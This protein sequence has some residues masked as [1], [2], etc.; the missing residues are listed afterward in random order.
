[1]KISQIYRETVKSRLLACNRENTAAY[2]RTNE[3]DPP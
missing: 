3:N 1:M 2:P